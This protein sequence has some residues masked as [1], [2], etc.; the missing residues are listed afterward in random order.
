MKPDLALEAFT[1][2]S[3]NTEEHRAQQIQFQRGMGKNY[4]RLEFLGDCFLK[5]ATSISLFAQNPDNDEF[6][7]HVKR[8][9][10]I[11]NKNLFNTAIKKEIYRYIR[12]QGFSRYG[13]FQILCSILDPDYNCRHTWY[14]ERLSLLKGKDH[15]K[16]L[17][18]SAKHHLAEKTIADVCE[19]LIGA[20]LL[21]GGRDNRF[22][23]AVKAVTI[24]VDNE[25]HGASCW[26][27]YISV[28]KLPRY[29][30]E[31]ATGFEKKLAQMIEEKLGHQF[32]YP[33]LLHSACT[34]PSFPSAWA[35]VPCYQRLEFLGDSLLDMACVEDL[36]SRYPDRDPQ[37]LTEHKVSNQQSSMVENGSLI[38][39]LDGY[40]FQQVLRS[41]GNQTRTPQAPQTV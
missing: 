41:T 7:F 25:D 34:H 36:F 22:D 6:D 29:Q 18:S 39:I 14:P 30:T 24:L 28:Y 11:C 32:N 37:W 31:S 3:D 2:D 40:G 13:L 9:C 15:S 20:A 10:L 4:E 21:S 33:R 1:K 17:L 23:M 12:S 27:D 19:A 38:Y 5:M 8:M 16:K 26:K 35:T